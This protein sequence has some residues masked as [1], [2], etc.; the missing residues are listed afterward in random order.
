MR[1]CGVSAAACGV[2]DTE[3]CPWVAPSGAGVAMHALWQSAMRLCGV[4]A[5][6]CGALDTECCPWVAP[7]GAGVALKKRLT[8][9]IPLN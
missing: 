2:L 3:C 7:S 8:A 4:P 9:Y 6:A 5:A 1:L